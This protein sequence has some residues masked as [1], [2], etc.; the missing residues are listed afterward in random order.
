MLKNKKL[1]IS[2]TE[3]DDPQLTVLINYIPDPVFIVDHETAIFALNQA[4]EKFLGLPKEK[5]LHRSLK[6]FLSDGSNQKIRHLVQDE[7]TSPSNNEITLISILY[8]PKEFLTEIKTHT[9]SGKKVHFIFF[10]AIR[11]GDADTLLDKMVLEAN[12]EMER[13]LRRQEILSEISLAINTP[14]SFEKNINHAIEIIGT[15]TNVSRVYIFENDE[16]GEVTRNTFEWCNEGIAPQ[17]DELQNVPYAIIPSWRKILLDEGMVFSQDISTLPTDVRAILE[18]QHILSIVVLPLFFQDRFMGFMGFDECTNHRKWL[19]S[20]IELLKTVTHMT[21]NSFQRR[22]AEESLRKREQENRA[23]IDSIPDIIF[24]FDDSGTFLSYNCSNEEDL[25]IPA[26]GFLYRN[27]SDIFPEEFATHM[28]QA[29]RECIANG[30]FSSEYKLNVADRENDYE[31][32]FIKMNEKEVMCIIRDVSER[33]EHEKQLRI[34]LENAEQANL[35]KSLF[36]ANVSHEIRTPLNA[37]LGFSEVLID[38]IEQPIYKSHLRTIISS[39]KTLLHLINDILDLSKIEAGKIEIENE[40]MRLDRVVHEI[41][42]IFHTKISAKNLVFNATIDNNLPA[43]LA[44]DEVRIHQILFNLV[45]NAL[46]F[47]EKGFV[48]LNISGKISRDKK[49]V[50]LTIRV[51][52][53]GIGIPEAQ[54]EDIFLSFTQQ[55]GQSTRKYGGTGL[56]LAI[57]KRLVEKFN[58]TITLDSSVGKGSVFSVYIP[59]I[60]IVDEEQDQYSEI[61]SE[62]GNLEFEPAK[63]MIV[64]DVDYNIALLINLTASENFTFITASSGEKALEILKTEIPDIIF[65]DLRMTGISGYQVTEILKKNPKFN[66]VP[67]IAFTAS[68]MTTSL[69]AIKALFDGYL[70]KPVNKKQI[71]YFLKKHLDYSVRVKISPVQLVAEKDQNLSEE[72]KKRLPAMVQRLESEMMPQWLKVKDDLII[73]EI[74]KFVKQCSELIQD[75]PCQVMQTYVSALNESIDSFDIDSIETLL[76]KFPEEIGN[77]KKILQDNNLTV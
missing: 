47:T 33:K 56:G 63:I 73:F 48:K 52:D 2:I 76:P 11:Q 29:I 45:G 4:A 28:K 55:S 24:H 17:K 57:T 62:I 37:I 70:R 38:K 14:G 44:L 36:L 34:A 1:N 61:D 53:T 39:G 19:R 21:S 75:Y 42:Q 51:E 16:T 22:N 49:R 30:R 35:A 3:P 69:P 68:A 18:P 46:K 43:F 71:Y 25:I 74:Q 54:Q 26:S 66:A 20:E 13:N 64:D 40:P 41:K 31:A 32:R 65:M 12:R 9:C 27:L 6:D 77:V 5:I 7:N 67:V 50:N 8:G 58:G 72:C 15:Y 10:T 59:D 60:E 23:I